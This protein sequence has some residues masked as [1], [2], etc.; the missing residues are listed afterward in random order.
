MKLWLSFVRSVKRIASYIN[1]QKEAAFDS[2]VNKEVEICWDN[3]K[4]VLNVC[5]ANYS[6]GSLYK[7]FRRA[8]DAV[9]LKNEKF[10]E[11]LILGN[12]AGGAA[13]LLRKEYNFEG[14]IHGVELDETII[15]ISRQY[16]PY[17]YK[18]TDAIFHEDGYDFVLRVEEETYDFVV[19]DIYKELEIPEKFQDRKFVEELYRIMKKN[20][21]LLFN[22][23]VRSRKTKREAVFLEEIMPQVFTHFK[24]ISFGNIT[25][26]RMFVCRK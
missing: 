4:R 23:V 16:F 21:I 1:E 24:K 3:G 26:N 20:G 13:Y 7:T 18:A 15:E 17:G 25:E 10:S 6:F 9:G 8:F 2:E 11:A 19:F 12:G 14:R 22:K 5:T